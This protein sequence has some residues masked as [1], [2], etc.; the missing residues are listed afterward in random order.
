MYKEWERMH[1]EKKINFK[2]IM[3]KQ[4]KEEN[5]FKAVVKAIKVD[6]AIW[7][8]ALLISLKD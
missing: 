3:S 5:I 2:D 4:M 8:R 1:G 7:D 6:D